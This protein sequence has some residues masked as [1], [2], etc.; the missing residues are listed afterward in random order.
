[1]DILDR[2]DEEAQ[3]HLTTQLAN[4][5]SFTAWDGNPRNCYICKDPIPLGRLKAINAKTCIYCV[6]AFNSD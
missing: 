4:R 5:P 2:A 1:M 3:I 6:K